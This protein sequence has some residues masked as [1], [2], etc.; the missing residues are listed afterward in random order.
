VEHCSGNI[1][2]TEPSAPAFANRG[3]Q[4]YIFITVLRI[5]GIGLLPST[6]AD[7]HFFCKF[8][9]F[10]FEGAEATDIKKENQKY[11]CQQCA[12]TDNLL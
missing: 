2:S 3:Q 12:N 7:K 10:T 1:H 5:A 11:G 8:I 4:Q 9:I 6:L